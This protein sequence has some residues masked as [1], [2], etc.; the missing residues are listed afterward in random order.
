MRD[1]AERRAEGREHHFFTAGQ[2]VEQGQGEGVALD[3]RQG[4]AA[5][6]A[7]QAFDHVLGVD[8]AEVFDLVDQFGGK[9]QQN[10]RD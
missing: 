5:T 6:A 3:R 9:R 8:Q 7:H 4:V 2:A 1:I 10:A